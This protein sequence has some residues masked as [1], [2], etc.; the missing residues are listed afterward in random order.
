MENDGQNPEAVSIV[1]KINS[2][3]RA[4]VEKNRKIIDP[5]IPTVILCGRQGIPLRGRRESHGNFSFDDPVQNDGNFLSISRF[6]LNLSENEELSD[7][8]ANCA[9]NA[10]YVSPKIQNEIIENC[11]T[12]IQCK[13]ISEIQKSKYFSILVDKTTDVSNIEQ[14]SLCVRYIDEENFRIVERL[15]DFVPLTSTTGHNMAET[16]KSKLADLG[17]DIND[18]RGQGYNGAAAMSGEFNGVQSRNFA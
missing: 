4:E 2:S 13:I 5:V 3:K 18:L 17:L 12:V 14:F 16:I 10:M 6:G 8:R 9:K 1:T 11:G 15:L 7:I